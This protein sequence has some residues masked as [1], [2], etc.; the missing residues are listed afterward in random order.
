MQRVRSASVAGRVLRH[1][2]GGGG[3]PGAQRG[4]MQ[5]CRPS[6][7]CAMTHDGAAWAA[8]LGG[9]VPREFSGAPRRG[10]TPSTEVILLEVDR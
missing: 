4:Q 3:D 10:V 1:G 2:P 8:R 9:R 7:A 5:P 6:G